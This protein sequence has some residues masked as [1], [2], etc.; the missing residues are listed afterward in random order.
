M[1][2]KL[3]AYLKDLQK[4]FD[5]KEWAQR[6]IKPSCLKAIEGLFNKACT[7]TGCFPHELLN[8][9]DFNKNDLTKEKLESLLAEL[10]TIIWINSLGMRKIRPL[11][12]K[13]NRFVDLIAEHKNVNCGIEVFCAP[14]DYN[15]Y[16][17]HTKK[18]CDLVDYFVK[19]G[20]EKKQQL[21]NSGC[22]LKLL[23]LVLNASPAIQLMNRDEYI[24][25][26]TSVENLLGW[27]DKYH[28]AI[29][30]CGGIDNDVIYPALE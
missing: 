29:I 22:D 7:I 13:Q 30:S 9:I 28:F 17:G 11:S 4:K 2:E 6:I 16:P 3:I 8:G 1:P 14:E 26:L 21:D 20:V 10:R 18:S 5:G 23:V 25:L 27:G 19:K 24:E 12:Q 15:R